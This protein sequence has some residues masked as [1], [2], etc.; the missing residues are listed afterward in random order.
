MLSQ[1]FER[2]VLRG[3]DKFLQLLLAVKSDDETIGI[4]CSHVYS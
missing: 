2:C 1:G 4:A 3:Q